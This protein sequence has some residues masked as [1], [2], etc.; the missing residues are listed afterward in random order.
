MLH[1]GNFT[2]YDVS[3]R[4]KENVLL[5]FKNLLKFQLSLVDLVAVRISKK[6]QRQRANGSRIQS[7]MATYRTL[8]DKKKKLT[9]IS[10][11]PSKID[12]L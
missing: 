7:I 4:L 1:F 6:G 12:H 3:E 10:F 9:Q 11:G 2:L 5:S 8:T